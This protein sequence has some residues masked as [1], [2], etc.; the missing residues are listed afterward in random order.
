MSR[1]LLR[2]G[3]LSLRGKNRGVYE[4][5]L[6]NVIATKLG[7]APHRF[8][9]RVDRILLELSDNDDEL[10]DR[11]LASSFGLAGYARVVE[12]GKEAQEIRR[13]VLRLAAQSALRTGTTSFRVRVRRIDKR[14]SPNSEEFASTIGADI[15]EMNPNLTVDL[16]GAEHTV[17]VEIRERT[18]VYVDDR[19]GLRGLPTGTQGRG[20]V[21]LSAGIDSPVAFYRMAGRGMGL[22]ALYFDG[23]LYSAPE[24][25]Q[26]VRRVCR[27]LAHTH[28]PFTLFRL[29][30]QEAIDLVARKAPKREHTILH[31]RLMLFSADNLASSEGHQCLITGDSL[32][33]VASQSVESIDSVGHGVS[34]PVLRPLIGV[35]KEEIIR[36]ARQ[37]GTFDI[38]KEP[39]SDFCSLVAGPSPVT[40]PRRT[41]IARLYGELG[42]DA[43]SKSML[44]TKKR[45]TIEAE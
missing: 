8:E 25:E 9:K 2:L 18:Y 27:V 12:C 37:I 5:A 36:Q 17:T 1:F 21:L 3:E 15:R 38:S 23:G 4:Q 28:G 44:A 22:D 19:S 34:M 6:T 31:R 42:L 30:I 32:G 7:D 45:E 26:K 33:Q 13:T 14:F 10:A 39:A 29:N 43:V 11:A 35:D 24:A 41:R 40:R 20:L 16:K